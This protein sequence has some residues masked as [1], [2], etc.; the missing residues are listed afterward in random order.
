MAA[1]A[2]LLI[3]LGLVALLGLEVTETERRRV[4]VTAGPL[5]RYRS[6]R[7]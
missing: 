6:G 7:G 4:P 1:V 3:G 2:G 5:R